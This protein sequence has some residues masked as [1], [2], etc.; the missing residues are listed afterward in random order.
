[1]EEGGTHWA[2][3]VGRFPLNRWFVPY[4]GCE[5]TIIVLSLLRPPLLVNMCSTIAN[6]MLHAH[7]KRREM[8]LIN[9]ARPPLAGDEDAEAI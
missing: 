3:A 8:A 6:R 2:D 1:M 9:A 5:L 7:A 4:S